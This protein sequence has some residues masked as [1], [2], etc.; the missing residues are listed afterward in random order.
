MEN[1]IDYKHY[2]DC[3]PILIEYIK[4]KASEGDG[5]ASVTLKKWDDARGSA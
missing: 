2:F 4:Q 3:V 5:E 1:K